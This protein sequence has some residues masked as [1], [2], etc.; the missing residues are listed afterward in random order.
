[1]SSKDVALVYGTLD[2][3]WPWGSIGKTYKT[4][5]IVGWQTSNRQDGENLEIPKDRLKN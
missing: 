5:S 1:M 3:S 4:R 2:L